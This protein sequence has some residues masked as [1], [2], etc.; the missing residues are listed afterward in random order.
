MSGPLASEVPARDPPKLTVSRVEQSIH[1]LG[2]APADLQEEIRDL[3]AVVIRELGTRDVTH[4]AGHG[5][6]Q[7]GRD[8]PISR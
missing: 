6:R 5:C 4:C 7:A 3:R 8:L 1:C 2:T